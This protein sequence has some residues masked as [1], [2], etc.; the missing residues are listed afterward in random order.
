MHLVYGQLDNSYH[1][2]CYMGTNR[3]FR[4]TEE[5]FLPLMKPTW[6]LGHSWNFKGAESFAHLSSQANV[7]LQYD[8]EKVQ[9]LNRKI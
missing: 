8:A 2:C 4:K 9:S 1:C 5:L 6:L 7:I 3:F